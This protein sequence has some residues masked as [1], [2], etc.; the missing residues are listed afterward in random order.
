MKW[1]ID[2]QIA[3]PS[4]PGTYKTIVQREFARKTD[5]NQFYRELR[6]KVYQHYHSRYGLMGEGFKSY[7]LNC[8]GT[9]TFEAPREW[10]VI[11]FRRA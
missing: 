7:A 6:A 1:Q 2:L 8:F 9:C 10:M 3:W 11:G 5:A 4:K